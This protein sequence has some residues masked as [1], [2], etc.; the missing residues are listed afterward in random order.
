ML[1]S[2]TSDAKSADVLVRKKCIRTIPSCEKDDVSKPPR[3][4]GRREAE[5]AI[6]LRYSRTLMK[7]ERTSKTVSIPPG[8][9]LRL[10]VRCQDVTTPTSTLSE[11]WSRTRSED[12][13]HNRFMGHLAEFG[14]VHPDER[15]G[16]FR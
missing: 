14:F 6:D 2:E 4:V 7:D 1:T 13:T 11:K 3:A 10:S 15:T 5:A 16:G 9:G 12:I 8:L